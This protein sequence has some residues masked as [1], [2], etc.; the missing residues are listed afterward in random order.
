MIALVQRVTQARMQVAGATV[1]ATAT[2]LL[3]PACAQPA[4]TE[5]QA[6]RLVAKL[7]TVCVFADN[8]GKMNH[9]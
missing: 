4:D 9:T 5:V 2:G 1:G 6:G 8:A 7:L 3:L